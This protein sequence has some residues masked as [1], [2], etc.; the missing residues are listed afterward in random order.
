MIVDCR[1]PRWDMMRHR[2]FVD[3]VEIFGVWYIDTDAGFVRTYDLH[4]TFSL[5]LESHQF[6]TVLE[7]VPPPD[8]AW[9]AIGQIYFKT[10][11]GVVRLEPWS[12]ESP[13]PEEIT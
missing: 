10:V 4:G 3:D 8:P 12:E 9:E 13:W 6:C 11:R 2:V 1:S 7:G 5:D